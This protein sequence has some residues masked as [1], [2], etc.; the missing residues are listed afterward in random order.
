MGSPV[1]RHGDKEMTGAKEGAVQRLVTPGEAIGASS[2]ARAGTGTLKQGDNIISTKLGYAKE[3]NGVLFVEPIYSAYLPRS[4]DLVVGVIESVRNNLWFAEVNGPFNGL[5][6][7]SLAPWKVEFGAAREHMDI[8][9]VMLARV[10]EVDEAHNIVLT[11]KGVGLRKLK[12]GSVLELPVN[13]IKTIRENNEEILN[14]LKEISDCRII[15]GDNGR[16]WV[17]GDSANITIARDG[18]DLIKSM[19]HESN[20]LSSIKNFANERRNN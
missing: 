3:N 18:I 5:L 15:V 19:G 14:I 10:Q 16:I 9:D 2:G 17:D 13:L 7:M 8:G 4:G 6:P 12:E 11:M 20:V 1:G